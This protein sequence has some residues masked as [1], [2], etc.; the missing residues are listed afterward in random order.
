MES[1]LARHLWAIMVYLVRSGKL[2]DNVD[3]GLI[4]DGCLPPIFVF[5]EGLGLTHTLSYIIEE[6]AQGKGLF[7]LSYG[8]GDRLLK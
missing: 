1:T 2:I 3:T 8:K 4:Y 6:F 7:G 5:T